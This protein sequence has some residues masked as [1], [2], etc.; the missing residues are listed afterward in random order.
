MLQ[1][2]LLKM[3]AMKYMTLTF[4]MS[5]VLISAGCGGNIKFEK[6]AEELLAQMERD[7]AIVP[8]ASSMS[9]SQISSAGSLTSFAADAVVTSPYVASA[10]RQ[11]MA[12]QARVAE[13][14]REF[15]PQI[16]LTSDEVRTHQII[17]ESSNPSLEG[18]DTR[19]DTSNV[20]LTANLRLLDLS[21]SAAIVAAR[22]EAEA[23][24]ADFEAEKQDLLRGI[25]D[26]YADAAEA[27]ERWRL[28]E[29]EVQ[30]FNELSGFEFTQSNAGVL[31]ASER[32]ASA[33]E[34]AR[35]RSD[36]SIAAADYRI[37]VDRL[38]T[39]AYE[40][41]CPYPAVARNDASLPLPT[42]I[43]P[44]ELDRI[45]DSPEIRAM[46]RRVNVALRE[47]DQA[48]MAMYP[49]MS[50]ELVAAERDRTGSLFDGSSLTHTEDVTLQFE[51][52]LFTSGRLRAIRDAQLNKAL[53]LGH[54]YDAQLQAKVNDMRSATSALNALWRHDRSLNEIIS[55]RREAV[56]EVS[57]EIEAGLANDLELA[58]ANLELVRTEVLQQRTRRNYIV[59]T[60]ARARAT[61]SVND[62]LVALVERILSD[63]RYSKLVYGSVAR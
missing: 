58:R 6:T 25:L 56:N 39:M 7:G 2:L 38:C 54:D 12:A 35:A 61:G 42:K 20:A 59:A 19:Y 16:S 21:M 23:R 17:K 11:M 24:E 52:D 34:L 36:K 13:A 4:S 47:V 31:R 9:P 30:Y 50:L 8:L 18:N 14:E 33:A 46:A 48:R 49:R 1:K 3:L 15:Y 41:L 57:R 55:L 63:N 29:A 43:S 60:I 28:A 10:K 5:L 45:E 53:A 40:T 44:D 62:K 51:W 27:I 37:R 26:A 32:S 22:S